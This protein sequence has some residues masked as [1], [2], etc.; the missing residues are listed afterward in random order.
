MQ[1][2]IRCIVETVGVSMSTIYNF[3]G[4]ISV[5]GGIKTKLGSGGMNKKRNFVFLKSLKTKILKDPTEFMN[6]LSRDMKVSPQ[7]IR[8]ALHTDLQLSSYAR[9]PKHLLRKKRNPENM[10]EPKKYCVT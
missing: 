2:K 10:K 7:T 9:T 5:G 1:V 4:Q 6:K 8:K 3:K